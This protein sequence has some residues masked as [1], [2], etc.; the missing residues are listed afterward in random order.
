[1]SMRKKH[2]FQ[3]MTSV[4]ALRQ[5]VV[6]DIYKPGAEASKLSTRMDS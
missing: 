6:V 4:S 5:Y 2:V 3:L 1:M